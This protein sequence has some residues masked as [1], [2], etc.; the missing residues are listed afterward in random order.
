MCY[1]DEVKKIGWQTTKL[2]LDYL[3]STKNDKYI[4]FPPAPHAFLILSK[5]IPKTPNFYT[6]LPKIPKKTLKSRIYS[7]MMLKLGGGWSEQ[8]KERFVDILDLIDYNLDKYKKHREKF[9]DPIPGGKDY[10]YYQCVT[11]LPK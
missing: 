8:K 10:K 2:V 5:Q 9:G 11:K 3:N 1:T 4:D 7:G 6:A